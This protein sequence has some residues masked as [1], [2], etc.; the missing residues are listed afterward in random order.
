[1]GTWCV[2]NNRGKEVLCQMAHGAKPFD[3]LE[4]VLDAEK[5]GFLPKGL[6]S[7]EDDVKR[8]GGWCNG[9]TEGLLSIPKLDGVIVPDGTFEKLGIEYKGEPIELK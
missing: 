8:L 3:Y 9:W 1:M 7:T 2:K 5:K 4:A 6:Y